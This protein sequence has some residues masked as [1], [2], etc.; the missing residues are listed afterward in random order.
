VVK[1]DCVLQEK[2]NAVHE[3]KRLQS[4]V[5]AT[6]MSEVA[7]EN[8]VL[9]D[10]VDRLRQMNAVLKQ[11]VVAKEGACAGQLASVREELQQCKQERKACV[12]QAKQSNAWAR[13]GWG[14]DEHSTAKQMLDRSRCAY[15]AI[16]DALRFCVES[17]TGTI[18]NTS[19]KHPVEVQIR[20]HFE[21]LSQQSFR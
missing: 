19:S 16:F 17:S 9:L 13:E 2:D 12:C 15:D 18:F 20:T 1:E 5:R 21:F 14:Y 7:R 4:S 3:L 6:Q 10:E 8:K 11:Q